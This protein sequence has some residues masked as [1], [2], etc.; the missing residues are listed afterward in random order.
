MYPG[1]VPYALALFGVAAVT[2]SFAVYAFRRSE[3]PGSQTL[4]WL[5][6]V[7]S[8]WAVTYALE[9][10]APSLPGKVFAAKLQYIGISAI[11]PL[12]LV[13]ALHY[14]GRAHWLTRRN[15]LLL[16][17]PAAATLGL[18]LTNEAHHLIWTSVGL[19][20]T[21]FPG[22]FIA[23]HGLW[24]WLHVLY[25]YVCVLAGLVSYVLMLARASS[26]YRRQVG[27]MVAGS[28]IPL[29]GNAVYVAGLFPIRQLDITPFTFAI[30]GAVLALGLFRFSLLDVMPIAAS[31]VMANL[32]DAIIVLDKRDRLVD[33]NPAAQRLLG[34]DDADVGQNLNQVFSPREVLRQFES[35]SE[36]KTELEFG[37]G[38][39]RRVV[40]LTIAPLRDARRQ[41]FGR[42]AQLHDLTHERALLTAE[43]E[44]ARQMTLLN[45]ITQSALESSDVRQ[46]LRTLA[47]RLGELIGAENCSITGWAGGLEGEIDPARAAAPG[48]ET[49]AAAVRRAGQTLVVDEG[50]ATPLGSPRP[51]AASPARSQIGLP[52][53]ADEQM[54]GVALAT[55]PPLHHFT[56][57]AIALAERGAQQIAL[58]IAKIQ[59]L[60]AERQ[61]SAELEALRQASLSLSS[62]LAL[63][64]ALQAILTQALRLIAADTAHLLFYDGERLTLGAAW[65][66]GGF[67]PSPVAEV[68]PHGLTQTVASTGQRLVVPDMARHPLF[69]DRPS[70]GAI[71]GLPLRRGGLVTG[72]MNVGFREPHVFDDNELR[73]LE[74]LADQAAVALENAQLFEVERHRT[75]LLGLLAEVGREVAGTLDEIRIFQIAVDAL[76]DRF[77]FAEAA[78]LLI[79][80]PAEL[81]LVAIAGA[82]EIGFTP[83]F[84]LPFGQGIIGHVAETQAMY[85]ANDIY[86][87]PYYSNPQPRQ[88]GS[89]L[90]LPVFR[91]GQLQA[92]LYVESNRRGAFGPDHLRALETLANHVSTAMENARLYA[93][94]SDRL[95]EMTA[96]QSV[97]RIVASSLDLSQIFQTAVQL[98]QDTLG[99]PYVSIYMLEG[100]TLHLGAQAGYTEAMIIT[101]IPLGA[102]I[103]GRTV[104]TRQ[105]QFI[106][107]VSAEPDFLRASHEVASEICVPLLKDQTALGALNV[108]ADS[109]RPLTETDVQLLTTLAGQVTVA[110]DNARLFEAEREQRELAET[111]REVGA[112]L[113]ASLAFETVLDY[114][115]EQIGRVVPYDSATIMLV[116]GDQAR[117]AR[118]RGY[119]RFGPEAGQTAA[120]ITL[121]IAAT[122]YLRRMAATGQPYIVSD[123]TTDPQWV[124]TPAAAHVRSWAGAPLMVRG[125]AIAFFS[126][127]KIEPGFYRPEHARRLAA[128]ASQAATALENARLHAAIQQRARELDALLTAEAAVLSTL[129]LDP[130]LEN[131]LQAALAAIP[132]AEKGSILL[133]DP[134]T[135]GLQIRAVAGY[136]DPR[137]RAFVFL[138]QEGYAMSALREQRPLLVADVQADPT[139]VYAGDIQEIGQIR[140]AI[141]APLMLQL[142][143]PFGAD[144]PFGVIALDA[145]Q[146]AAFHP[147]DLRL[148]VAFANTAAVAIDHARLHAEVQ[149]LAVTDG[150]TGLANHRAFEHTLRTEVARAL[151]YSQPMSLIFLDVDAFKLYND[152]YGHPAGDGR[153]KAF[154][155]LLRANVRDPDLPARY[156]GEEFVIILPHT[157]K[158]GA[159]TLAERLRADAEAM[160]PAHPVAGGPAAGYT[161]SLGVASVPDDAETPEG[162]LLA[163]DSA[164]LAAKRAGKNRVCAAPLGGL[165]RTADSAPA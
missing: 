135:E 71:A 11:G 53:L 62:N 137:V 15:R 156:G 116:E 84:R 60:A 123:P 90:A 40:E 106:R 29:V 52:L 95:R 79:V 158:A 141:A 110:I 49:L 113:S 63:Q 18:A 22:L 150:L 21:G 129:E 138:G 121:E 162:L 86:H 146:R 73:A 132:A 26:L 70:H 55:Y 32:D 160:A 30:S 80:E 144:R 83:G 119:E 81:E 57:A 127:D 9:F 126:V 78:I 56:P 165:L 6:A 31:V 1:S 42:I 58:G 134:A 111:L 3:Q 76:V 125:Q 28:L 43:R 17:A 133:E 118:L 102:G 25:I 33:F 4:G 115:I 164:E 48:D 23:G 50:L 104:R 98:L 75:A 37:E 148:L 124:A 128:L 108:E 35:V 92:V 51:A 61:R 41:L 122:P 77:G 97:S 47:E 82:E 143:G 94:A 14:T 100:Q 74:L 68:R 34:L 163:A 88:V 151:R 154:A 149:L 120:A 136:L 39:G 67:Q 7:M 20:P 69:A 142:G 91:E 101:Q 152:T 46:V 155:D 5:L 139:L 65:W 96:L 87:D 36:I 38:A 59:A 114:L 157:N 159:L 54:L 66:A 10:L 89:A 64:P 12:W 153:L 161:I 131:I 44:H 93:S 85:V 107:D 99:Y 19:D 8:E 112:T 45:A 2:A 27:I 13:F 140:S 109:D 105:T 24:F 130:L 117:M 16:A 72:V 103:L 147:A 145:T